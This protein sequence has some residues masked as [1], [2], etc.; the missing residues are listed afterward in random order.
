MYRLKYKCSV[1]SKT[2]DHDQAVASPAE[3]VALRCWEWQRNVDQHKTGCTGA[4]RWN[5]MPATL[6]VAAHVQT[7]KE[8][9]EN[10]A[11]G[12]QRFSAIP[13]GRQAD[14]RTIIGLPNTV[15]A[16]A[17]ERGEHTSDPRGPKPGQPAGVQR[18]EYTLGADGEGRMTRANYSGVVAFYYSKNHAAAMYTYWLIVDDHDNPY[19]RGN[20]AGQLPQP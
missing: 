11:W 19:L 14:V 1:C 2:F 5:Q 3:R 10:K 17:L 13:L 15:Y 18:L 6:L 7:P 20:A 16:G 8:K 4:V 12:V 9:Y